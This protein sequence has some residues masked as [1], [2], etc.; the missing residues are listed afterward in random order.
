MSQRKETGEGRGKISDWQSKENSVL[1][2]SAATDP[3]SFKVW[4]G[5]LL[6]L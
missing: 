4:K 6:W 5:M 1:Y 3:A 2:N